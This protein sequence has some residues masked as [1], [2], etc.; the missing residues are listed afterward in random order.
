[1]LRRRHSIYLA[2]FALVV[3]GTVALAAFLLG[4]AYYELQ[5]QAETDAQNV[6]GM[7]EARLE[8]TLRRVEADLGELVA[9]VPL[10]SLDIKAVGRF[11]PALHHQLALRAKHF[12]EITGLRLI[13]H[14][15][16]QPAVRPL[17][18]RLPASRRNSLYC[19]VRQWTFPVEAGQKDETASRLLQ[20]KARQ[21]PVFVF[22]RPGSGR[23]QRHLFKARRDIHPARC[24]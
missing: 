18:E 23:Q 10:E 21:C 7:L 2:F 22:N 20:I 8:A 19:V 9:E 12:P 13:D 6:V 11:G 15:A 14:V 4:T 5:R 17:M 1:M 24:V 16:C 3:A